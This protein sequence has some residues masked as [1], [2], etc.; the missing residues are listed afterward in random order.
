MER[1]FDLNKIVENL[2]TEDDEPVDNPFS[3]KQQ[4]FL[5]ETLYKSWQ[6][7]DD[8]TGIGREFFADCNV[9]VFYSV[10]ES[11]IVPD[12]FVSLDVAF[13]RDWE[14]KDHRAYFVWELGKVPDVAVE[15]V[16]FTKGGEIGSK[17]NR[18]A[19]IGVPFYVV[20]D[21]FLRYR[22]EKL[23]IF[24]LGFGKR[25]VPYQSRFLPPEIG[26]GL[27]LWHGEF[28][29][30]TDEWLRWTDLDGNLLL[31]GT[32]LADQAIKRAAEESKR[33]ETEAKRADNAEAEIA[34]LRAELEKLQGK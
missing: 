22:G 16:P 27:T 33:A 4:R 12:V 34:E 2:V 18:Y 31:N 30:W 24:Q 8:D 10:F 1:V 5:V 28:E 25:Y 7:V 3:A 21:P 11:P 9:G 15:I 13:A 32:E 20:F 26:L 17:K 14:M 29:T 23:Q 6:P 19:H